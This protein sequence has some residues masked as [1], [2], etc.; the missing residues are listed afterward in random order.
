MIKAILSQPSLSQPS[1]LLQGGQTS[2]EEKTGGKAD[3]KRSKACSLN[4]TE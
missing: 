4:D 3:K 2:G 1:K